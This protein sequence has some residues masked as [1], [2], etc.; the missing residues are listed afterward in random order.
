MRFDSY[1]DFISEEERLELIAWID[2]NVRKGVLK[3]GLHTSTLKEWNGDTEERNAPVCTDKRL[4]TRTNDDEFDFPQIA[5]DIQQRI[6]K[7]FAFTKN[8]Y[9]ET[10]GNAKNDG[11][12]AIVT[13]PGGKT[14]KHID[15]MHNE[16]HAVR[17]NVLLQEPEDGGELFI[18]GVKY[19]IK[20]R[21]L[22]AYMATRYK[23]WVTEVKGDKSRYIWLFGFHVPKKDWEDFKIKRR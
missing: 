6:I 18:E 22:H 20:E 19:E 4:T 17:F 21:E 5:Y 3:R 8:C 23:H 14:Y 12:I 11:M 2:E 10:G 1:P 15:P 7:D 13:K 9:I 16:L